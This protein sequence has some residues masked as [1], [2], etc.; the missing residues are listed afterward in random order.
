MQSVITSSEQSQ[1]PFIVLT[2]FNKA[3]VNKVVSAS[4]NITQSV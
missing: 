4:D 1:E 3:A 2:A